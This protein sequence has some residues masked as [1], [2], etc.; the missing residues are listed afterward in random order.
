MNTI[1]TERNQII[2]KLVGEVKVAPEL[3]SETVIM[4]EAILD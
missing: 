2:H 4:I 3:V 1:N